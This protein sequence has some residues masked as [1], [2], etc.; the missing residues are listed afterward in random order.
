MRGVRPLR[1]AA[2][3]SAPP[4]RS[5][6]N[7]PVP[8]ERVEA[9]RARLGLP[10]RFILYMGGIDPRKNVGVLLRAQRAVRERGQRALPLVIVAPRG[11]LPARWVQSDPRAAAARLA[12]EPDVLFLDQIPDEDKP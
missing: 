8:P 10:E 3:S 5:L 4:R 1:A 7:V 2:G 11:R 9:L 12:V 6:Y